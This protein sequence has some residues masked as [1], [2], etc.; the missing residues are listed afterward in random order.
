[1]KMSFK[2]LDY[3]IATLMG[4]GTLS[5]VYLIVDQDWNML[6]AM[7]AG[8]VLGM[9]V[10]LLTVLLFIPISTAFE[11]FPAG[12]IITMLIGMVV[13]MIT[14]MRNLDFMSMLY[15]VIGCSLFVQVVFD[16]YN[17]KL[18]GEVPVVK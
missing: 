8:M 14:S 2:L 4:T 13:G 5:A 9:A 3:I 15:P 10:L 1:M 18:A 16:L 6:V 17:L 7:V 11:L 12:M